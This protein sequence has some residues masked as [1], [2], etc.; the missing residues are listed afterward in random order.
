MMP[1]LTS[2]PSASSSFHRLY[3]AR[4]MFEAG[5]RAG[6]HNTVVYPFLEFLKVYVVKRGFLDG[7]AGF[8]ISSLHA[9]YVFLKYAK[10]YEMRVTARRDGGEGAR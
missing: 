6:V 5:R 4:Q 3:A 9:Y 2:L 1:K 10:L 7:L 8:A